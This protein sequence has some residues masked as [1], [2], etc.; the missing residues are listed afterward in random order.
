MPVGVVRFT[1]RMEALSS[2]VLNGGDSVVSAVFIM[3]VSKNYDHPDPAAHA[4]AALGAL[5][6]QKPQ[7]N[8][9]KGNPNNDPSEIHF[10]RG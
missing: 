2:A 1:E 4:D 8:P 5:H 7:G 6:A 9:G 3:Q 10:H